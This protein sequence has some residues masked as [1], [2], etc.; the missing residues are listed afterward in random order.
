ME[1]SPL[2]FCFNLIKANF[3][4]MLL[5]VGCLDPPPPTVYIKYFTQFY[6]T[7]KYIFMYYRSSTTTSTTASTTASSS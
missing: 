4:A 5:L 7:F 3:V 2:D 6:H 1:S